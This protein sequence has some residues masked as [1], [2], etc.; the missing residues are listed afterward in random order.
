[1]TSQTAIP[2]VF[3]LKLRGAANAA[4]LP[5]R[6]EHVLSGRRHDFDS[7]AALLACLRHE[8]HEV[9]RGDDGEPP[10]PSL[11]ANQPVSTMEKPR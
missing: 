4:G 7:A 2:F 6:I 1:M 10:G 8:L 9:C 11:K 3:V 5:G